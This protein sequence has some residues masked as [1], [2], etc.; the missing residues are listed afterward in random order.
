MM[1]QKIVIVEPKGEDSQM[2]RAID[3]DAGGYA[4]YWNCLYGLLILFACILYTSVLTFIPRHNSILYPDYWY[5]A[6]I[7]FIGISIRNTALT[8]VELYIFTNAKALLS[9]QVIFKAFIGIWLLFAVPYCA[10]YLIWT[11]HLGYHHP[12]PFIGGACGMFYDLMMLIAFWL[13]IPSTLKAKDNLGRQMKMY[14]LYRLWMIVLIVQTNVLQTISRVVPSNFQ[15]ILSVLIP[16]SETGNCWVVSKIARKVPETNMEMLNTLLETTIIVVFAVFV[17][18][19]LSSL[20]ESTVYS[21]LAIEFA[22]HLKELYDIIKVHRKISLENKYDGNQIL[23]TIET[24]KVE[25]LIISEFVEGISPLAYAIGFAM[26]YYGFNATLI[27]NVKNDYFGA[28]III[29]VEHFYAIMFQMFS[30]NII[31]MI[32]GSIL[33]YFYCKID[34]IKEFCNVLKKYWMILI[35]K[36]PVIAMHFGYNDINFG[37]DYTMKFLWIT[38]EGRF[39]LI[40]NDSSLSMLQK[41]LLMNNTSLLNI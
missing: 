6:M 23:S 28:E 16:A 3:R 11:Y 17:T 18:T 33:L 32:L 25:M 19:R 12:M 10:G 31:A 9:M 35:V 29:D 34:F 41:S 30:I 8:I 21:I 40:K 27:R 14:V 26:A 13:L 5:E 4:G 15:W 1:A 37:L 39:E 20:N 36:L 38:N 22:I 2:K 7:L 24:E